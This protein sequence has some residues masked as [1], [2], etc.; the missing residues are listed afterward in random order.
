MD[1]TDAELFSIVAE[2]RL[3]NN[4]ISDI[5]ADV[6]EAGIAKGMKR[7]KREEE[8]HRRTKDSMKRMRAIAKLRISHS[9][10]M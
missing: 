1:T 5:T 9:A 10:T 8:S 7:I 3:K 6:I 4:L 2:L